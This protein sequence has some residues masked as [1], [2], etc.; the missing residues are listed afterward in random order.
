M[1]WRGQKDLEGIAWA[2]RRRRAYASKEGY[3]TTTPMMLIAET[4]E[5]LF[6]RIHFFFS[7]GNGRATTFRECRPL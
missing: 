5:T 7:I 3:V 4:S 1:P 2:R 6:G